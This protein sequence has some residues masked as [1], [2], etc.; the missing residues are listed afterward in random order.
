MERMSDSEWSELWDR[1]EAGESQRSLWAGSPCPAASLS[2]ILRVSIA[3][4]ARVRSLGS[5]E[6]DLSGGDA[7]NDDD[8]GD[9]GRDKH[10][11]G[12]KARQ[13]R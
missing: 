5:R 9:C 6:S 12:A 10:P 2:K 7:A 13:T 1:W 8:Q 11:D 3:S 4:P